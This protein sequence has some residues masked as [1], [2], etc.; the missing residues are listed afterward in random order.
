MVRSA[1]HLEY[2]GAS[3]VRY[4]QCATHQR[5]ARRRAAI[6]AD[7]I[8]VR[9]QPE[10]CADGLCHR[11]ARRVEEG[12]GGSSINRPGHLV[13]GI[14]DKASAIQEGRHHIALPIGRGV[15]I[16]PE[17]VGPNTIN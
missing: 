10:P 11:A 13:A 2:P 6:W 4:A 7:Y 5:H 1:T 15:I 9:E 12:V 14:A 17:Y 3:G 16:A 8:S